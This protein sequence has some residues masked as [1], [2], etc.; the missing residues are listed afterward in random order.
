MLLPPISLGEMLHSFDLAQIDLDNFWS[1][2][3][4]I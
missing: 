3:K 2:L 1:R 4:D